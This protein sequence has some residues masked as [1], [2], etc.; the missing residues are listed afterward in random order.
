MGTDL[1]GLP[2]LGPGHLGAFCAWSWNSSWRQGTKPALKAGRGT[3]E[4]SFKG[5]RQRSGFKTRAQDLERKLGHKEKGL[6]RNPIAC[7]T[8]HSTRNPQRPTICRAQFLAL[9]IKQWGKKVPALRELTFL[10][11]N[12]SKARA[13]H[14]QLKVKSVRN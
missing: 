10:G 9:Q 13:E 4:E 14:L 8:I 3:R 12:R 6:F 7:R 11:V 1:P 5:R 2:Y